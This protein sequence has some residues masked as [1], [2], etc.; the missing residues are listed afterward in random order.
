MTLRKCVNVIQMNITDKFNNLLQ[1]YKGFSDFKKIPKD[2][3]EIVVIPLEKDLISIRGLSP[4]RLRFEVEYGL[5]KGSTAN[6]FLF[7][8]KNNKNE[9][10]LIHPPGLAY[11]E[12]FLEA[13]SKIVPSISLPSY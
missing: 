4:K 3:R 11:G 9:A 6:S 5:E 13:L 1:S 10:I 2:K 7:Y 12:V 8:S